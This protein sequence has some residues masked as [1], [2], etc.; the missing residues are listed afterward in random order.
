[1]D[2]VLFCVKN[3]FVE[4]GGVEKIEDRKSGILV[5]NIGLLAKHVFYYKRLNFLLLQNEVIFLLGSAVRSKIMI[6]ISQAKY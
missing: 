2:V 6:E 3:N 4:K 1:M 5:S